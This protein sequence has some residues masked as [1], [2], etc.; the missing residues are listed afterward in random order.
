MLPYMHAHEQNAQ[1]RSTR[2]A[3]VIFGKEI[4]VVGRQR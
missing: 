2:E 1:E 4:W 3:G